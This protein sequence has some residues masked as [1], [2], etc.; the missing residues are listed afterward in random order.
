MAKKFSQYPNGS[1]PANGDK[2]LFENALATNS[3]YTT[4]AQLEESLFSDIGTLTF[5]LT[6]TSSP[7]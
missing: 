6:N 7:S 1:T 4:Y 3:F 5:D 2:M